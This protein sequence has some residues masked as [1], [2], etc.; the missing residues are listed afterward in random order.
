MKMLEMGFS[1]AENNKA[2]LSKAKGNLEM[3][4]DLIYE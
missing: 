1:N 2:A 4:I 3:A